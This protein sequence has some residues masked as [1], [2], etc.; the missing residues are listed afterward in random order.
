VFDRIGGLPVHALVLHAAVVFIPLL[1]LAAIVY[2]LVP[3]WRPRIGWAVILLAIVSPITTY[4][5]M[6]SGEK[7]YHRLIANGVSGRGRQ[8]LD[9]HM[10][11]GTLTFWFTLALGVIALV[12]VLFTLR[13][14][15]PLP[16]V[17]GAVLG[18]ITVALALASG[19]YVFR[20]GDSG[21]HAVWGTY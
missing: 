10:G 12:M 7:L 6:E 3:R 13:R 16:R 20:T 2:T 18:L 1:A 11:F 4:V 19:Y 8:M 15:T 14:S 17:A 5:T 9:E 21:A